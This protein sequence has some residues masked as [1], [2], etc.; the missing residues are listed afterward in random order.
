[1]KV[2]FL[3]FGLAVAL[4]AACNR[5]GPTTAPTTQTFTRNVDATPSRVVE[6]TTAIFAERMIPVASA[7]Q[8]NGKVTSV[9]LDPNAEWGNVAS[10]ERV[11]CSTG[12][13]AD[14][15]ARLVLT[16][17]VKRDKERSV[18]SI[19]AKRDGGASCVLRGPFMTGLMDAIVARVAARG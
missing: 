16:M 6:A 14:P 13:A 8:T 1:M 12:A 7:D 11:D 3:G 15:N 4:V 5:G 10:T 2:R 18:L 19:E 9:P 17:N